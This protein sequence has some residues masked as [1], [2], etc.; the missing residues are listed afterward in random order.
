MA[1]PPQS[2]LDP[3]VA[4]LV[5]G[6]EV[7][8]T[9]RELDGSLVS[10]DLSG[11]TAL[12]ERLAAKGRAGAEELVFLISSVFDGLISAAAQRGGDVLKFRGDALLILFE[13]PRHEQRAC[14]AAVEMQSVIA[15]TGRADSSVGHVALS[16]AT[17]VY[18]GPCQFFLAGTSHHELIVAGP[19]ATATIRL[20]DAAQAGEILVSPTTAA[21]LGEGWVDRERDGAFLLVDDFAGHAAP[22]ATLNEAPPRTDLEQFVPEPLREALGGGSGEAEHR[23]AATA[24][25]KFSGVEAALAAEG[26]EGLDARIDAFAQAVGE[27]ADDNGVTWLESDID[28][29]GGKAYLIAGVPTSGGFDEARM[30]RTVNR[31]VGAD[32]GLTLRAGINRGRVFAGEIGARTR[33][34]YAVLGDTVNLAARL[35]GRAQ[36]GQ[37][38]ST[39]AVLDRSEVLFESEAQPF[40]VKGKERAVTAYSV[41]ALIGRREEQAPLPLPLIGRDAELEVARAAV[42]AARL[43]QQRLVEVV[44]EP[45]IGKSRLLEELVGQAVGFAQFLARCESHATAAPYFVFR[46]ILRQLAGILPG[47]SSEEAGAQLVAWVQAVMPDQ[48]AWLP[49]L[50]VP[51]DATV[52]A[53]PEVDAIGPAFRRRRLHEV[54]EQFLARVLLMPTLLVFEDTH[55]LDGASRELLGALLVEPAPRPWLVCA[56]RRP[57]GAALAQE[58]R[59]DHV[60][61]ALAPLDAKATALLALAADEELTLGDEDLSA[62]STRSGGNPL[63][64]RELVAAASAGS[65][66][67]P[68]TV[69]RLMTERIDT[70]PAD[71]RL[72][73]RYASVMGQWFDLDVLQDLVADELQEVTDIERWQRLSDFVE[74]GSEDSF[75]FRHELFRV[76][77]YEGLS[78]RRRREIHGLV[79]D[80]LEQR[81]AGRTDEAAGLLSHHFLEAGDGPRAWRYSVVAGERARSRLANVDATEFFGRAL[82]AADELGAA[83]PLEVAEIAE[84]LGDVCELSAHYE[85]AR[86]AYRRARAARTDDAAAQLRLTRK[87]GTLLE[88]LGN[89]DEAVAWFKR[90]LEAGEDDA[91]A[92][93]VAELELEYAVV[94]YRQGHFA[95]CFRVSERAAARAQRAG[96]RHALAHA[97]R[98][99]DSA[100][101]A[102]GGL[103]ESWLAKALPIYEE[104]GDPIGRAIT[105]N[106]WG[107]RAY[108]AGRWD[109]AQAYYAQSREA[110]HTYGDVVRAATAS[111]NEAEILLDQGHT[112][113]AAA[114]FQDA[115]R[116]YRASGYTF[117]AAVVVLN[118]ARAEA[119]AGRFEEAH[120]LFDQAHAELA[121]IGSESFLLELD[122]RRSEC[123]VLEGHYAEALELATATLEA[124]ES[125]GEAA[126]RVPLLE[127]V[128][129]YAHIQARR[130]EQG[131]EHLE[132]SL[133]AARESGND[134]E[135]ALTLRALSL[136]GRP[137]CREEADELFERLGVV[138]VRSVPL[139]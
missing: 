138:S 59:E 94:L 85:D 52:P 21:A 63:F 114:L 137:E 12:S 88:R 19:A 128:R 134:F 80:V 3:Y 24:F 82:R 6:W 9:A 69:E 58:G 40:L 84:V 66:E 74:R 117:G 48:A 17:G 76:A 113:R 92:S 22:V 31:I 105:L 108:Y 43:R 132:T 111:N 75:F 112:E 99:L 110:E 96:D 130:P 136:T 116:V 2:A 86:A 115:L 44:G 89:Y 95:D 65:S 34:T 124:S 36:P 4:R 37:I 78:F 47:A 38:L 39:G 83:S 1:A 18:S 49:L 8:T 68:E 133:A 46:P 102:L 73:L 25:V 98:L 107:I 131:R 87:E 51:F 106:N 126:P 101:R 135:A 30:L 97:Y 50:A 72:L 15:E 104:L 127:R 62:V 10:V 71:D 119:A 5:R 122:M 121:E 41:G 120:R 64:V 77:A 45:G 42:N 33:H 20:E 26:L 28:V 79:G 93:E 54:V 11:F 125:A 7:G 60:V 27:A 56:T 123:L 23:Q 61:L 109:E 35:T 70:L 32:C 29:D 91:H 118:L 90:A 129:G 57:A 139:P 81:F 14:T 53:T 103:D 13:G 16:M 67:L 55:W 100:D